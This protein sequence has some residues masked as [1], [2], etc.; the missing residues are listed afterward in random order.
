VTRHLASKK[1]KHILTKTRLTNIP[2]PI[3]LGF[4]VLTLGIFKNFYESYL[5]I[6]YIYVFILLVSMW[7]F[8]ILFILDKIIKPNREFVG[9]LGLNVLWALGCGWW[10]LMFNWILLSMAVMILMNNYKEE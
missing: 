10:W 6:S 2:Y 4:V 8:I 3:S 7:F 9:V 5:W 1:T